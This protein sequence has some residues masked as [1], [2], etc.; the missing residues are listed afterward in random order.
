MTKGKNIAVIMPIY[1]EPI[2]R[3]KQS[4]ESILKQTYQEFNY[5]IILD[6]PE[7]KEAEKLLKKYQSENTN[8][9]IIKNKQNIWLAASLNK[10]IEEISTPYIARMDADDIAEETRLE[11]QFNYMETHQDVDLLFTQAYI[12]NE[13]GDVIWELLPQNDTI[14]RIKKTIFI[15][16]ELIHPSLLARREVLQELQYD[17]NSDQKAKNFIQEDFELRL[18]ALKKYKIGIIEKK[19]IKYRVQNPNNI[20]T[21][22]KKQK[23]YNIWTINTLKKHF[24]EYKHN[25]YYWIFRIKSLIIYVWCKIPLPLLTLILQYK[26][27]FKTWKNKEKKWNKKNVC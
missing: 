14:K 12:I 7:Y 6:N 3:I 10:A 9:K 24:S 1:K 17:Q 5:I 13:I 18:R 4:I 19:L 11:Q 26:N 8:L 16:N 22:L 27:F 20:K 23:T 21:R 2:S 15:K 25:P